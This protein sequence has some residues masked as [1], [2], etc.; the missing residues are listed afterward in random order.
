MRNVDEMRKFDVFPLTPG[1][2][3]Y[4][5]AEQFTPEIYQ[6]PRVLCIDG[7]IDIERIKRALTLLVSRHP[8]LRTGFFKNSTNGF[9]AH[10]F[11]EVRHEWQVID[12]PGADAGAVDAWLRSRLKKTTDFS[13]ESLSHFY[14]IRASAL[15]SFLVTSVHHSIA[16][17]QSLQR[18]IV[19][20][21]DAYSNEEVRSVAR[22]PHDVITADWSVQGD[23]QHAL[24]WWAEKLRNVPAVI[25]LPRDLGDGEKKGVTGV[26]YGLEPE[27]VAAAADLADK[28]RVSEFTVWYATLHV[29][30]G[31]LTGSADVFSSFQ[32]NGRRFLKNSTDSIGAYSNA[33]VIHTEID[34]EWNFSDFVNYLNG[35]VRSAIGHEL[36]P[37]HK[38][39]E[40][41]GVHP[42]FGVNWYPQFPEIDVPELK[43]TDIS[44]ELWESDY[45]LNFR[46]MREHE[47]RNLVVYYAE[48]E[49]SRVRIDG[50]VEQLQALIVQFSRD[51]LRI[52]RRTRLTELPP[53]FLRG[54][55]ETLK[56]EAAGTITAEFLRRV[57]MSPESIAIRS[58]AGEISYQ[59][60]GMRAGGVGAELDRLN[61]SR[62]ARVAIYGVRNAEFIINLLGVSVRGNSFLIL[63]SGYPDQR[64]SRMIEEVHAEAIIYSVIDDAAE[65]VASLGNSTGC[66]SIGIPIDARAP[67]DENAV[68]PEDA[69]YFI[70]TSGTTGWPKGM[71][72][73]HRPLTNFVR[74]HAAK[75]SLTSA[76]RFSFFSGLAH[77]PALRDIFTPLSVGATLLIPTQDEIL[78]PTSLPAWIKKTGPTVCHATPPLG[79]LMLAGAAPDAL[80]SIRVIFWGGDMLRP[81]LLERFS[82]ISPETRHVNFYGA[83]ETPQAA[84]YYPVDLDIDGEK[85]AIPIGWATGGHIAHVVDSD[86]LA[87][88]PYEPGEVEII[89]DELTLGTLDHGRIL[90]LPDDGTRR[91][92]R[93][94][95]RGFHHRDG[96]IQLVGRSDDQVKIRGYRVEPSEISSA[97]LAH[98]RVMNACVLP[99]ERGGNIRLVAFVVDSLE[100]STRAPAL[101]AFLEHRLPAYML[102]AQ[103]IHVD[104]LPLLPNGKIDR[105]ALR[106]LAATEEVAHAPVDDRVLTERESAL[107]EAWK[108]EL[109]V[110]DVTLND[111]LVSL[112]GDSL[113]FVS[114][115]LATEKIL[116]SVPEG[117]QVMTIAELC[118]QHVKQKQ[119]W[120]W[121]DTSMVVRAIAIAVVVAEHF[122]LLPYQYFRGS[123][124]GLFI[125]TGYFFGSLQVSTAFSNRSVRPLLR[126][127][128]NLIVPVMLFSLVL[129][130]WQWLRG[131]EPASTLLLLAENLKD[132]DPNSKTAYLWYLHAMIQLMVIFIFA[133]WLYL[134]RKS[135]AVDAWRFA[136]GMFWLSMVLKFGLPSLFIPDFLHSGVPVATVWSY[137]PTAHL[138]TVTLGVLIS[139]AGDRRKKLLLST[140][141]LA[142]SFLH[143]MFS[144]DSGY[145][146]LIVFG[147]ALLFLRRVPLPPL[148]SGIVLPVS[149]ASLYIYLTHF[150]FAGILRVFNVDGPF[151]STLFSIACGVLVWRVYVWCSAKV[152]PTIRRA[153]ANRRYAIPR[154][155]F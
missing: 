81:K 142:Y 123:T 51:P 67:V 41:T 91:K 99:V 32:S 45:Q 56:G 144:A 4:L 141:V 88:G 46:F 20:L 111:S 112:G 107:I 94:G 127:L 27:A 22:G 129:Y 57:R 5:L 105:G 115:Y 108:L 90:P 66:L 76:D 74:W 152:A 113:N 23:F 31:R 14:L 53:A 138:A 83:T 30:L 73:S 2:E 149:G 10:V 29:L 97:L 106:S 16:D 62:N 79:E 48:A 39:I 140:V 8:A 26:T 148:V 116:G 134:R 136:W 95:D 72:V 118:R 40:K 15:R 3:R 61:V 119:F 128:G 147:V 143:S 103:F 125:I 68:D 6:L 37:Y 87:L 58:A 151:V 139:V 82:E 63:D 59:E 34:R 49:L 133:V 153:V 36:A 98:P 100:S 78:Q 96:S 117:W 35:E 7:N 1:E 28:L 110:D 80:S 54:E 17:G 64:L 122:H 75:F 50:L 124:T 132:Y 18:I 146:Y 155:D 60:L 9:E 43:L 55:R 135:G 65:R 145:A 84:T 109:G 21:F 19:E 47:R 70:F 101:T 114:V 120:R 44:P 85:Y 154:A 121:A 77:D 38:V 42:R 102:P 86:G 71:V 126:M 52:L 24:Q 130:L 11:H 137:L 25:G 131:N 12:M 13:P 92:Y 33:L 150:Q 69:A 104:S 93:T 89:A